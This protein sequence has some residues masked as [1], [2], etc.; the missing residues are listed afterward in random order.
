MFDFKKGHPHIKWKTSPLQTEISRVELSGV[1][2][3]RNKIFFTAGTTMQ[4]CN[5]NSN[6][7]FLR[8][9]SNLSENITLLGIEGVE[10]WLGGVRNET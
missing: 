10:F 8:Y 4:G 1:G 6:K 3:I 7:P 2:H 5:R 9:T